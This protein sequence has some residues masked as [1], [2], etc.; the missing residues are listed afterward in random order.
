MLINSLSL[1]IDNT[2]AVSTAA[3][4]TVYIQSDEGEAWLV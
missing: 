2:C 1:L 3:I 4:R